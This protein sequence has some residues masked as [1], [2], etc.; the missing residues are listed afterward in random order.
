MRSCFPWRVRGC[1]IVRVGVD[2]VRNRDCKIG[3]SCID[4]AIGR[5]LFC[6]VVGAH[7]PTVISAKLVCKRF[8]GLFVETIENRT[9]QLRT[10]KRRTENPR[11]AGSIPAPA[12]PIKCSGSDGDRGALTHSTDRRKSSRANDV[13]GRFRA[14]VCR[15]RVH[16]PRHHG[17]RRARNLPSPSK[18]KLS[19]ALPRLLTICQ[20]PPERRES[21]CGAVRLP[22]K[23][24]RQETS[25]LL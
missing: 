19:V 11:V 18:S 25:D 24:R 16:S 22:W 13:W 5:V 21:R 6:S 1:E 17:Q 7:V 20:H 23:A 8:R 10:R 4:L 3:F 2:F 12:T 15:V 14:S 9:E